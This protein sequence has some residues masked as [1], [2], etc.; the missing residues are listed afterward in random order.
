MD[1]K[2]LQIKRSSIN[3]S[4]VLS[5][6]R[7][8]YDLP[9]LIKNMKHSSS[10]GKGELTASILFKGSCKRVVLTSMHENTEVISFQAGKS[11]TLQII[12]GKIEFRTNKETII[13]NQGQYLTFHD[14]INYSLT[15]LEDSS[16]LLTLLACQ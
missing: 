1:T 13:L 8:P 7:L 4:R 12:E 9:V 14:K 5:A 10:W 15:S 11:A 3:K 16:F 6:N 2:T